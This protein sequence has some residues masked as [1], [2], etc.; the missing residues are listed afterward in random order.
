LYPKS[1]TA[2]E[3]DVDVGFY[4]TACTGY[5]LYKLARMVSASFIMDMEDYSHR[6][7][8]RLLPANV[9]RYLALYGPYAHAAGYYRL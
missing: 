7:D 3:N 1:Q 4:T 8:G 2:N 5:N 9:C 6:T